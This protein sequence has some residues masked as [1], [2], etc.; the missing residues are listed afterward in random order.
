[1][2]IPAKV[3]THKE[4]LRVTGDVSRRFTKVT[5]AGGE[6]TLYQKL[7]DMLKVAKDNGALVNIVTN[8]SL[9]DR[10]WL[11]NNR[12]WIDFLTISADSD[13]PDTHIKMGRTAKGRG[14]VPTAHYLGLAAAAKDLGI[15]VKLNTVVTTTNQHEDM[16]RF[17]L[18]MNPIRWKILQAMPIDGQN[19]HY[20]SALIPS[21][22][23]FSDYVKR[24]EKALKTSRI[25]IVAETIEGIRCSYVMID[26]YGRFFDDLTGRY[27][28]GRSILEVG[29]DQA[30]E[31]VSFDDGKFQA[32]GGT[33][34]FADKTSE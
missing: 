20:I 30:W 5:F 27:R 1:V 15:R 14:P 11:E 31:D 2:G 7:D 4:L 16:T 26:P 12:K 19:D 6:P 13:N 9:I 8:A 23:A 34:D 18:G 29:V 24:H 3:L 21:S 28:Y 32:R 25:R 17:V 22:E 33:A 10:K